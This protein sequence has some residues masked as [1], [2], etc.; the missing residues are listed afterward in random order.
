M[1]DPATQIDAGGNPLQEGIWAGVDGGWQPDYKRDEFFAKTAME[2]PL[3][4]SPDQPQHHG[5]ATTGA[6]RGL[7]SGNLYW[8]GFLDA[9][10]NGKP[11]R[12]HYDEL[13]AEHGMNPAGHNKP[14]TVSVHHP[15]HL[16]GAIE[17]ASF[18]PLTDSTFSLSLNL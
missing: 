8:L 13:L 6:N 14:V 10:V 15:E 11:V 1:V 18:H 2:L 16:P 9:H 5:T 12:T 3:S 4:T 7:H 17:A